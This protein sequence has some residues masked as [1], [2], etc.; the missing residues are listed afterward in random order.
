MTSQHGRASSPVVL[1]LSK[2]SERQTRPTAHQKEPR[3]AAVLAVLRTVDEASSY[4]LFFCVQPTT[5]CATRHAAPPS[6]SISLIA[7]SLCRT[8]PAV[9][10]RTWSGCVFGSGSLS[11]L[12]HPIRCS[13]HVHTEPCRGVDCIE[14]LVLL[15]HDRGRPPR[16]HLANRTASS[17][18][19]LSVCNAFHSN[20]LLAPTQGL[21]TRPQPASRQAT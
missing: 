11:T 15:A 18:P 4:L 3:I 8:C 21:L 20:T 17:S 16:A 7:P 9:R 10:A 6:F 5:I 14:Q 13:R 19:L 2:P 1:R 12:T